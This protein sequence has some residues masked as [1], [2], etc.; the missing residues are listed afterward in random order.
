M[1]NAYH[2]K[3]RKQL[4]STTVVFISNSNLQDPPENIKPTS[5]SSYFQKQHEKAHKT[6]NNHK[7]PAKP[8]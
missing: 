5:I 3:V 2:N 8:K 1:E 4:L 7:I 6:K